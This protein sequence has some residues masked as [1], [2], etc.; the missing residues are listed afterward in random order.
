[1]S[2]SFFSLNQKRLRFK[3]AQLL[4]S[5][6]EVAE[7]ETEAS[8]QRRLKTIAVSSLFSSWQTSQSHGWGWG[9]RGRKWR[10]F[11]LLLQ[12]SDWEVGMNCTPLNPPPHKAFSPHLMS[13]SLSF[14]LSFFNLIICFE[15][16]CEKASLCWLTRETWRRGAKLTTERRDARQHLQPSIRQLGRTGPIITHWSQYDTLVSV[17]PKPFFV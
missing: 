12:R 3:Q 11:L 2:Q 15:L 1:M 4:Q 17:Q 14:S 7:A 10:L 13:V 6:T 16:Y 9:G 8:R 5:H